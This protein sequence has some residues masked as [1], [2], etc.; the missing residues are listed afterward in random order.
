MDV[1]VPIEAL[2]S[3]AL[4]DCWADFPRIYANSGGSVY[5][6]VPIDADGE[7]VVNVT[8]GDETG[9][10][11]MEGDVVTITPAGEGGKVYGLVILDEKEITD[12]L[13]TA[14]EYSFSVSQHHKEN[15]TH[16]YYIG[17]DNEYDINASEAGQL[18]T[19]ITVANIPNVYKLKIT[20]DIN[21]TDITAIR[22]MTNLKVLDLSEANIVSGGNNYYDT[23]TTAND[24]MG[25]YFFYG[26]TSL[27]VVD[28]PQNATRINAYTFGG[29]TGLYAITLPKSI[30]SIASYAFSGCTGILELTVE[31]GSV[32][33]SL[34][35]SNASTSPFCDSPITTL[36]LG[37]DLSYNYNPFLD[38]TS[39]TSVTIGNRVSKV[40]EAAFSGC[41][42]LQTVT[43]GGSVS[44]IGDNAFYNCSSLSNVA[45]GSGTKSIGT[46]AFY[47]C[48]SL[49]E[50]YCKSV[51]HPDISSSTFS[52]VDKNSC[53]LY[54]PTGSLNDYWL[55]LF[56]Q[57]F[58]DIREMK[59]AD[60]TDRIEN[61]TAASSNE[62]E[63]AR[64]TLD[65]KRIAIPQRGINI[66]RYSDGTVR[67]V[68]VP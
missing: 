38:K 22:R 39:L 35:G 3:Y 2:N 45:I 33:L 18:L 58:F 56:W 16:T 51:T 50:I 41:A 23:Y 30:T 61:T 1:E 19:Q 52:G 64:Y 14:S 63:V 44:S 26:M 43:M 29:C 8:D 20:G 37:R 28:L 12:T 31:D 11:A 55:D 27:K 10:V 62:Q 21:G 49:A 32:A 17:A 60:D 59:F 4:A 48:T 36:Y 6:P 46:N 65:G 24:V 5:Y 68:L 40:E 34:S 67:K 53:I 9:T 54:V 13:A 42:N 66:I 7:A 57:E 25:D 47:N 15:T